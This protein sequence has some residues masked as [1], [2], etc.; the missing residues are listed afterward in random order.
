ML[1]CRNIAPRK[2]TPSDSSIETVVECMLIVALVTA[3][4]TINLTF[5][6]MV[7]ITV[8][9]GGGGGGWSEKWGEK[10]LGGKKIKRAKG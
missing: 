5:Y 8:Q 4:N 3:N 7:V 2:M 1:L 9:G 6:I 10:L